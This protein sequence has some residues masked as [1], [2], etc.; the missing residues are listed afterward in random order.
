LT[1]SQ[2]KKIVQ[3]ILLSYGVLYINISLCGG[4]NIPAL[5]ILPPVKLKNYKNILLNHGLYK[6]IFNIFIIWVLHL[7][8]LMI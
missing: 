7:K 2:I 1:V 6:I 3:P 4:R 8:K 5:F